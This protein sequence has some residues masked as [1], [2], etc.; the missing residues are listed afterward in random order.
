MGK[1]NCD[2]GTTMKAAKALGLLLDLL[3]LAASLGSGQ[4]SVTAQALVIVVLAAVAVVTLFCAVVL[5]IGLYA[6]KAEPYL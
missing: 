4:V 1:S 2:Q 3:L 5:C 6:Q